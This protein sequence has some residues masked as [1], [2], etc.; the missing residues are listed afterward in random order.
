MAH[1]PTD[2]ELLVKLDE[3]HHPVLSFTKV[4]SMLADAEP[5]WTVDAPRLQSALGL[6]RGNEAAA[7]AAVAKAKLSLGT[8]GSPIHESPQ[9]PAVQKTKTRQAAADSSA[10][11]QAAHQDAE[12]AR[13]KVQAQQ[14]QKAESARK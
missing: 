10:Q 1:I 9:P 7:H 2:D 12:R 5:G 11:K 14:Q 8:G 4:S 3:V 6:L 13:N